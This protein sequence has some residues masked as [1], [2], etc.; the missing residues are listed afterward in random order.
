MVTLFA[1]NASFNQHCP[2]LITIVFTQLRKR[3][4]EWSKIPSIS[5]CN[6]ITDLVIHT[7]LKID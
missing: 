6:G 3:K 7:L 2:K 1:I 4:Q 5:V